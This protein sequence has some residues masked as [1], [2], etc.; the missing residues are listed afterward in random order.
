[1]KTTFAPALAVSTSV[2]SLFP[3]GFKIKVSSRGKEIGL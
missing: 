1:M 3:E 2:T